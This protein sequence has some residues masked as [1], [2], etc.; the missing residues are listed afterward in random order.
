MTRYSIP[1]DAMRLLDA[2]GNATTDC[3]MSPP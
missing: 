1:G 3:G 2:E